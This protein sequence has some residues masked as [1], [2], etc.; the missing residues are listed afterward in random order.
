MIIFTLL[1]FSAFY[2]IQINRMT[3]ALVTSRE[4]PEEKHQKIFRTIN[5]LITLLLVTF[6]VEL[7]YAV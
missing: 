3:F 1:L 5:I 4:I 6:Y 2:L 7:V